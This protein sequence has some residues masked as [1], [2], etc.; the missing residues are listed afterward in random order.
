MTVTVPP[1]YEDAGQVYLPL[2]IR[3]ELPAGDEHGPANTILAAVL[4]LA[5]AWHDALAASG[6]QHIDAAPVSS[7]HVLDLAAALSGAVLDWILAWPS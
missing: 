1:I 2:A 3:P 5:R 6:D 4:E 7:R